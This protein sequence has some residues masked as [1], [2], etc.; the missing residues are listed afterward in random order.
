LRRVQQGLDPNDWKPMSSVGPGVR[1]IRIRVGDAYRVFYVATFDEGVYV[2][3]AFAKKARKT[4]RRDID[5]GRER[6]RALIAARKQKHGKEE[7]HSAHVTKSRGDSTSIRT[8]I[9]LTPRTQRTAD[10][11]AP[12]K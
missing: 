12:T 3:H 5:V 7:R 2:I 8:S 4:A 10:G 6:F 9:A 11:G 1:E